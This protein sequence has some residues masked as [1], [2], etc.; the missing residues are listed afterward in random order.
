MNTNFMK[1]LTPSNMTIVDGKSEV[2]PFI[3]QNVHIIKKGILMSTAVSLI[4]KFMS[5]STKEKVSNSYWIVCADYII[6]MIFCLA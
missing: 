1:V 5:K 3:S 4:L 6:G 2:L